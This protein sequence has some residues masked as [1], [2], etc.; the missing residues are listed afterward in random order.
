MAESSFKKLIPPCGSFSGT[1]FVLPLP[2]AR[3]RSIPRAQDVA[4]GLLELLIYLL[5]AAGQIW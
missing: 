1:V 4:M 2:H 5:G 3:D